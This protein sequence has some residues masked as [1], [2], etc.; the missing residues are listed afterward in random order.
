M[1]N[2]PAE[3]DEIP[4]IEGI[5]SDG[6]KPAILDRIAAVD[7]TAG[8]VVAILM[9]PSAR[10]SNDATRRVDAEPDAAGGT[11]AETG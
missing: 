6:V 1:M 3:Q 10:R 4:L 5:M 8:R 7:Y 2:N 11:G 9:R